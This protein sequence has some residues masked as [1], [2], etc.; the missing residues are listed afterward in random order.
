MSTLYEQDFYSWTQEQ[1]AALRRAAAS[2]LNTPPDVDWEHLAEEIESLSASEL[3]ELFSRYR[4]LMLHLLKWRHQPQRRGKSWVRTI[5]EQRDQ[6]ERLLLD[7]PSLAAKRLEEAD[8]AYMK[9]RKAAARETK[10]PLATFPPSCPFTLEQ[11]EDEDFWP[12]P[13]ETQA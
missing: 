7:S 9:A 10:L 4:I 6:I 5:S 2:R 11:V 8:R 12:E 13:E 3:R 1:A